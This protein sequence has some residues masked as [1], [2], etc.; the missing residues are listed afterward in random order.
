MGDS[1]GIVDTAE[2]RVQELEGRR[3]GGGR[4]ENGGPK[5]RGYIDQ[6]HINSFRIKGERMALCDYQIIILIV[7]VT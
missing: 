3:G 2:G 4:L 5:P 7:R 1:R 6:L